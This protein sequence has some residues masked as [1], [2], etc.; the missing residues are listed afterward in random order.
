MIWV[1]AYRELNQNIQKWSRIVSNSF[2]PKVSYD[3]IRFGNFISINLESFDYINKAIYS[4]MLFSKGNNKGIHSLPGACHIVI[5]CPAPYNTNLLYVQAG[6]T[7]NQDTNQTSVTT[8]IM[9]MQLKRT[10]SIHSDLW[11]VNKGFNMV[12]ILKICQFWQNMLN[13]G[14]KKPS[15]V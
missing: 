13:T 10:P 7:D 2:R 6:P 9:C 3:P 12:R 1:H 4:C 11:M 8:R 15:K 5:D 14:P